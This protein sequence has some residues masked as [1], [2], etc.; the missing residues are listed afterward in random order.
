MA[1]I[2]PCT[3]WEGFKEIPFES[4][5]SAGQ[6]IGYRKNIC[7]KTTR[8]LL[9]HLNLTKFRS[10]IN[11]LFFISNIFKQESCF[12]LPRHAMYRCFVDMF[13]HLRP[14]LPKC[15]SIDHT[16]RVWDMLWNL[17]EPTPSSSGAG[18]RHLRCFRT[19]TVEGRS[20][21]MICGKKAYPSNH[22]ITFWVWFH[23][24]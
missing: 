18:R 1:K 23:G 12:S 21:P 22:P 13:I 5:S 24:T 2:Q 10:L 7:G 6:P 4:T 3:N 15:R 16:L 11:S 19:P 20:C 17:T 9:S 8:K 14:K